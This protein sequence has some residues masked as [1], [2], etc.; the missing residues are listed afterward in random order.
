MTDLM[1]IRLCAMIN[2]ELQQVDANIS[3]EL[4]W[5]RASLTKEDN[6]MFMENV[7]SYNEYKELLLDLRKQVEEGELV[8]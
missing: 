6:A 1:K 7:A 8:L 5:A 2:N 4:I 3:N